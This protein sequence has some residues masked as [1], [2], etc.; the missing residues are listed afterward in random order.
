M[1]AN[2]SGQH[3]I[4]HD[5]G[6]DDN[7]PAWSPDS[8]KIVFSRCAVPFGFEA[9]CDIEVV[10][11]DGTGMTKLLG[12]NWTHHGP[13]YSP[14]GQQIAFSSDRGGYVQAV[15]V[16]NSDGSGPRRLT[17]PAIQASG[18]EWSPGGSK[19]LFDTIAG[20]PGEIIDSVWVMAADG[21]RPRKLADDAVS[22][23]YSPNGRRIVLNSGL[24]CADCSYLS[25][26]NANGTDLHTIVTDPA[27][28]YSDWQPTVAT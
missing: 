7:G 19:I 15:W 23:S 17:K 11:A 1:N 27:V 25:V 18:P 21:S 4:T 14:D 10:N 28:F 12:G 5:P 16:M 8:T 26:M 9:Y 2:G 22:A 20:T 3:Q 6:F 13:T 24:N